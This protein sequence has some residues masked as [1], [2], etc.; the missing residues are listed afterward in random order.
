MNRTFCN[1]SV[2]K[3]QSMKKE[4]LQSK[5]ILDKLDFIAKMQCKRIFRDIKT[6]NGL[7]MCFQY[8]RKSTVNTRFIHHISELHSAVTWDRNTFSTFLAQL[9]TCVCNVYM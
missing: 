2:Q 8:T 4:C 1:E 9:L 3:M 6:Q 7:S 5:S